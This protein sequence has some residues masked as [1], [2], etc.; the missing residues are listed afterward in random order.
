MLDL[1]A[2]IIKNTALQKEAV[3]LGKDLTQIKNEFYLFKSIKLTILVTNSSII[4][5]SGFI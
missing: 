3:F 1:K 4:G 2:K 5:K